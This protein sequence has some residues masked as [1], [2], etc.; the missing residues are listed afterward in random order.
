MGEIWWLTIIICSVA[1]MERREVN[2]GIYEENVGQMALVAGTATVYFK[3]DLNELTDDLEKIDKLH[4]TLGEYCG[5]AEMLSAEVVVNSCNSFVEN[6]GKMKQQLASRVN[7]M[8][9]E[10]EK[11]GLIDFIGTTEKIFLV[12]W[13]PR[14]RKRLSKV[15]RI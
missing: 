2:P 14:I 6:S 12:Q 9:V 5:Q 13:T 4:V 11:R 10:R 8:I 7:K 1:S 3:L 15:W